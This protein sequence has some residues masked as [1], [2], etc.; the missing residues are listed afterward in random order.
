VIAPSPHAGLGQ[1]TEREPMLDNNLDGWTSDRRVERVVHVG[2][3]AEHYLFSYAER[4]VLRRV[5][6]K[7]NQKILSW[8]CARIKVPSRHFD[9]IGN[10]AIEAAVATTAI[11]IGCQWRLFARL[12]ARGVNIVAPFDGGAIGIE[13]RKFG[14]FT[15][16]S[17]HLFYASRL[18]N[19]ILQIVLGA[20]MRRN[21]VS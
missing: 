18:I 8:R 4:L 7:F 16:L 19:V 12:S 13:H 3:E 5:F 15:H 2:G 10:V 14:F 17:L 21:L 1:D 11:W 20:R 9:D 6:A